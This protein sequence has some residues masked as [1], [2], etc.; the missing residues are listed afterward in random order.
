M[1]K[2]KRRLDSILNEIKGE[3]EPYVPQ[4]P[5]ITEE[6]KSLLVK[7][8]IAT[9]LLIDFAV[10]GMPITDNMIGYYNQQLR[11]LFGIREEAFDYASKAFDENIH[12]LESAAF[13]RLLPEDGDEPEFEREN[14]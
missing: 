5:D 7:L 13:D 11:D 10:G 6:Q 12:R 3:N 4:L 1:G 14:D 8:S 2:S 9:Q